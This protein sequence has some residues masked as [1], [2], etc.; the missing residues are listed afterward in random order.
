M[1][2]PL[3]SA[4]AQVQAVPETGSLRQ[5]LHL[6]SFILFLGELFRG[7]CVQAF[8][9]TCSFCAHLLSPGCRARYLRTSPHPGAA[10]TA[11]SPRGGGASLSAPP[12]RPHPSPL[13]SARQV[14]PIRGAFPLLGILSLMCSKDTAGSLCHTNLP[15][16]A[17]SWMRCSP[18]ADEGK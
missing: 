18:G 11:L 14:G 10:C 8:P 6:P 4:A 16:C 7:G 12:T 3:S 9:W 1:G 15:A 13:P 2:E 17:S 5:C